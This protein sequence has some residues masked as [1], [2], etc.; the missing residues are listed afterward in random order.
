MPIYGFSINVDGNAEEAMKKI[1]TA[2]RNA[3]D[4]VNSE[5]RRIRDEM[6][7]TGESVQKVGRLIVEAFAVRE[8]INFGTELLHLKAEFQGFENVIK[9]SSENAYDASQNLDYVKSAAERLHLPIKETYES[10]SEMQ[11]GFYG[12]GIE[13][14]R[15]RK[16]FEGISTASAVMH[17]PTEQ[18]SRVTFALKEIGELGTVQARQMRM[19]AFALPGAMNLAAQAMHMTTAQFHEAMHK[20]EIDSTS[21]LMKFSQ[22]L[23]EHFTPGLGRAG[24]S[25]ISQMNDTKNE[26]I[27]FKLEMA[28]NLEP[29]FVN[30]MHTLQ[31]V[32]NS[33][34][35]K[36]FI[37]H[38]GDLV[39]ILIKL[40]GIW[41]TYKALMFGVELAT[42]AYAI[43]LK[44][45]EVAQYT[46]AFGAE[47]FTVALGSMKIA[48]VE[49]GIGAFAVAL[50][51][52]IEKFIEMNAQTDE[53]IEKLSHLK[54]V[55]QAYKEGNS[56]FERIKLAMGNTGAYS[57]EE[58]SALYSD[59]SQEL[60]T[61][62]KNLKET[63]KPALDE[64]RKNYAIEQ[65]K[66]ERVWIPSANEKSGGH[67]EMVNTEIT[68]N[69]GRALKNMEETFQKESTRREFYQGWLS[70]LEKQ[71]VKPSKYSG[72][73]SFVGDAINTSALGGA[74]GGLGEAK[75][76]NIKI[77]TMQKILTTDNK[78]LKARGQ[79][80]VEV[81]L[82]TLNNVAYSQSATQ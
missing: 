43:A 65:Q 49:T 45:I 52:V 41:I 34:P 30:I 17:L 50:G 15:L 66:K 28:D 47:G 54:T 72:P 58:K 1:G 42:K 64:A 51:L 82:R 62:K 67:W 13:G 2:I 27:K 32:F 76:I 18:F 79:D 24:H 69:L 14:E 68:E 25:L 33:E 16:V 11:A 44:V 35:V 9:Y 19:L 21:F 81:M 78:Q 73:N 8:L 7:S 77:D 55:T 22:K 63:M 40:T 20:G 3:A 37:K 80:A 38:I 57:A 46:A 60:A 56:A 36:L 61:I 23:E 71:G 29:V 26:F 53:A 31:T 48:M 74:K 12:T 6:N 75:V 4:K 10:F 59:I 39:A 5:G 70:D